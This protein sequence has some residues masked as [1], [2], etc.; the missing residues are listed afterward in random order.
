M[1]TLFVGP[2]AHN[3]G[4]HNSLACWRIV[5]WIIRNVEGCEFVQ[6]GDFSNK[7]CY[8]NVSNIVYFYSSFYAKFDEIINLMQKHPRANLY[9]LYNEYTLS[10]NSSV[11]NYFKSRGF[12]VITNLMQ[13]CSK[14][15]T[16][17]AQKIHKINTN[18]T[19][20]RDDVYN[21]SWDK[22]PFDLV[23]YGSYRPNRN[24]YV[25]EYF[26]DAYISTTEKN[27]RLFIS[28]G[29]ESNEYI[30]VLRW[31]NT[32]LSKYYNVKNGIITPRKNMT[33]LDMYKFSVYIED[34]AIHQDKFNNL[35]DRFYECL[36]HGVVLFFDENCRYN[37]SQ[38]KYKIPDYFFVSDKKQLTKKMKELNSDQSSRTK[39]F[40]IM[41]KIVDTEKEEFKK[42]IRSILNE[43]I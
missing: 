29:L 13:G 35:S 43:K 7:D 5:R 16:E 31:V 25:N 12:S 28:S 21:R 18:V 17:S 39:Y 8:R 27:E 9:W 20:Y 15:I 1:K 6:Y 41:K 4:S 14:D 36:S 38:S 30:G 19:A 22:K 10:L 32:D 40:S 24:K 23:Y 26:S 37:V 3:L 2:Y 11:S 33:S 34:E 42:E